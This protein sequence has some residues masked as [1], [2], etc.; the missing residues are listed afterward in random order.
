MYRKIISLIVVDGTQTVYRIRFWISYVSKWAFWIDMSVIRPTVYVTRD[1]PYFRHKIEGFEPN[2]KQFF[3]PIRQNCFST[4]INALAESWL[5]I[6]R[7]HFPSSRFSRFLQLFWLDVL[8][9]NL[10]IQGLLK[11]KSLFRYFWDFLSNLLFIK[12]VLFWKSLRWTLT[13]HFTLNI[14][15]ITWFV[16]SI[17]VHR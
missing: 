3:S 17:W 7:F 12:M 5:H 14:W 16:A 10:K 2:S 4:R 1:E 9:L 15:S 6:R 13:R 8:Q 11:V